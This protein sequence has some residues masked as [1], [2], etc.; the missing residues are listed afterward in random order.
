MWHL[1]RLVEDQ[2]E[3]DEADDEMEEI[4]VDIRR[5]VT[6]VKSPDLEQP[7]FS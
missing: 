6:D 3:Q 1:S 5:L 7:V 4:E 2:K